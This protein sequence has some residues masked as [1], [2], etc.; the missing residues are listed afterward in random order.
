MVTPL[1][2]VFTIAMGRSGDVA[3]ALLGSEDD[4]RRQRPLAAYD[5]ILPR[6]PGLPGRTSAGISRR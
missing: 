5:W 6:W 4:R 1:F 2:T 3:K